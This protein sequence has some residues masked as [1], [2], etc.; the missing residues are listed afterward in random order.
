MTEREELLAWVDQNF[1]IECPSQVV[2]QLQE[3]LWQTHLRAAARPAV[4]LSDEQRELAEYFRAAFDT[5]IARRK[6][7]GGE[8]GEFC[9]QHFRAILAAQQAPA[10][11]PQHDGWHGAEHA[12]PSDEQ[13]PADA[14]QAS[15]EQFLAQAVERLDEIQGKRAARM[16]RLG[17][18]AG[19]AQA[20]PV[21][22]VQTH[23]EN[24]YWGDIDATEFAQRAQDGFVTRML[25]TAPPA[26]A[27]QPEAKAAP[28][29]AISKEW[30]E[31]M[32]KLEVNSDS[33]I[34]AGASANN[35]NG[36]SEILRDMLAIQEACGLHTDEYAPGSV[37]EYIKELE[38]DAAGNS[39]GQDAPPAPF[40]FAIMGPDGKAYFDEHCVDPTPDALY[41]GVNALNDSPDAGYSVVPL[42]T[43]Q[44]A[45]QPE[46]QPVEAIDSYEPGHWFEARTIDEM[47]AFYLSRLP[48]IRA[49]AH[50]HGY[51][52]G[53]HGSTRRDF[54]LMAMQWRDGASDKDSLARAI[55]DAACGIRREGS[56]DWEKKPSGRVATSM[57]VCWTDHGNPDFD[58]MVSAGHID[59]SIMDAA[60]VPDVV[61]VGEQHG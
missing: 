58:N 29:V 61:P 21:Y 10:D 27:A 49:A 42:Y 22:Q 50:E 4:V 11:L 59:L 30:C 57:P 28:A 40:M 24:K 56:Y 52:I 33:N 2:T 47:Q 38:A 14:G 26:P 3:I 20:Q 8:A 55:A 23:A 16:G 51:A 12:I 35:V 9:R 31:R 5:P 1:D 36:V 18:D 46:Q 39:Q 53:L 32:A 6:L 13:A 37:I 45:A 7:D 15:K 17:I 25:Y 44:P 19:Q 60:T 43:A 48:A 54:D 41:G 34:E